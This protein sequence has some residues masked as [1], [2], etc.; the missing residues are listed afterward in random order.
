VTARSWTRPEVSAATAT[1]ER[2][3]ARD[4]VN[5]ARRF[6]E[7]VGTPC[8][9]RPGS[10][11]AEADPDQVASLADDLRRAEVL[12]VGWWRSI[13]VG[14][15][16]VELPELAVAS[17]ARARRLVEE[18]ARADWSDLRLL[19]EVSRSTHIFSGRPDTPT[20][21]AEGT[22]HLLLEPRATK[23]RRLGLLFGRG[24]E[25]SIT[26]RIDAL[27]ELADPAM[28][29]MAERTRFGTRSILVAAFYERR[30]YEAAVEELLQLAAEPENLP[31]I[32]RQPNNLVFCGQSLLQLGDQVSAYACF[33]LALALDSGEAFEGSD[34]T[35]ET[36]AI[37]DAREYCRRLNGL[38]DRLDS[39]EGT[40]RAFTNG[41]HVGRWLAGQGLPGYFPQYLEL[42]WAGVFRDRGR[43]LDRQL[44]SIGIAS[45]WF[46]PG[47]PR[48]GDDD[49]PATV[50]TEPP[51]LLPLHAGRPHQADNPSRPPVRSLDRSEPPPRLVRVRVGIA[52][53]GG[54]AEFGVGPDSPALAVGPPVDDLFLLSLADQM[55]R[56]GWTVVWLRQARSAGVPKAVDAVQGEWHVVG[57]GTQP[58]EQARQC[59]AELAA[60]TR[61]RTAAQACLRRTL[62]PCADPAADACIEHLLASVDSEAAIKALGSDQP[63]ETVRYAAEVVS[64]SAR[65]PF[66]STLDLRRAASLLAHVQEAAFALRRAV[67]AVW[68]P[69]QS[70]SY[71]W[72]EPGARV[73]VDLPA[74]SRPESVLLA[75]LCVGLLLEEAATVSAVRRARQERSEFQLDIRPRSDSS[76][77]DELRSLLEAAGAPHYDP[78]DNLAPVPE[79]DP[80]YREGVW[81]R[82]GVLSQE[83]EPRVCVIVSGGWGTALRP[84][85]EWFQPGGL[86]EQ[87][88]LVAGVPAPMNDDLGTA[89]LYRSFLVGEL[90]P[91][92][93]R[94]FETAAGVPVAARVATGLGRHGAAHVAA[95]ELGVPPSRLLVWP[96]P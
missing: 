66:R 78:Y 49:P 41:A 32:L 72:N 33:R 82:Q 60:S 24:D 6:A 84:L 44:R 77:L 29:V 73:R 76:E 46:L 1:A 13:A 23:E 79:P 95:E 11:L 69:P 15:L 61:V 18:G 12:E 65:L 81:V 63:L 27:R 57:P 20:G 3:Q 71:G 67:R 62:H 51:P 68:A 14:W 59:L 48:V 40:F 42:L 70:S 80:I 74:D 35:S 34:R 25:E 90:P 2:L 8:P 38:R 85:L 56:S 89:S 87:H 37:E 21:P 28:L 64:G 86:G 4:V 22:V 31:G 88:T 93:L 10:T 92:V 26:R 16:A 50:P 58:T 83:A 9:L 55:H 96:D 47:L 19:A 36:L 43:V 5:A 17:A 91:D 39:G 7:L 30:E 52:E 75:V 53:A 54:V 94:L 45:G